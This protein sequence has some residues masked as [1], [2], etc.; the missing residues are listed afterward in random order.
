MHNEYITINCILDRKDKLTLLKYAHTDITK[1]SKVLTPIVGDLM[2]QYYDHTK[3]FHKLNIER[4][5]YQKLKPLVE[6]ELKDMEFIKKK[7]IEYFSKPG[8]KTKADLFT[9]VFA[10]P[11][12]EIYFNEYIYNV[13]V[14]ALKEDFN[15]SFWDKYKLYEHEVY[16]LSFS[17]VFIFK[18]PNET[19]GIGTAAHDFKSSIKTIND[20]INSRLSESERITNKL[21][22]I[23]D[24]NIVLKNYYNEDFP[25]LNMP[26]QDRINELVDNIKVAQDF[27]KPKQLIKRK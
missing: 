22:L 11:I 7:F 2:D 27:D 12:T 26:Y 6:E 8:F 16:G 17:D 25:F 14:G 5:K 4:K 3:D 24:F 19:M 1:I 18:N 13:L 9:Y 21:N 20:S 15:K 10:F 23:K